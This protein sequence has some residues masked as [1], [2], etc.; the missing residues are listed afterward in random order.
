MGRVILTEAIIGSVYHVF[1]EDWLKVFPREQFLFIK[2]E[3]YFRNRTAVILD[4]MK[5]LEMG[6][7]Q[8]N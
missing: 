5:F 2:S 8:R 6:M 4:I 1:I 7:V 3:E